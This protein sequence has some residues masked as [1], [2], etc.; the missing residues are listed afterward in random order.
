MV[1]SLK[2]RSCDVWNCYIHHKEQVEEGTHENIH[3]Y[4]G[5]PESS[6]HQLSGERELFSVS[7]RGLTMRVLFE[8]I[9]NLHALKRPSFQQG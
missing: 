2:A 5:V 9:R 6:V 1:K 8:N 3:P 7:K 4:M